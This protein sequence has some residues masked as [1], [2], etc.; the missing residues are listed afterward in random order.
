MRY[1]A[2]D[3]PNPRV[4]VEIF[5]DF[6]YSKSTVRVWKTKNANPKIKA[7]NGGI[8]IAI[9]RFVNNLLR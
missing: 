8:I 4:V 9:L 3:S 7:R 1:S 2:K 5:R 6:D